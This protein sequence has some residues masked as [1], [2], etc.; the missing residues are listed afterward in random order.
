[1]QLLSLCVKTVY[2]WLM[3]SSMINDSEAS[4]NFLLGYI[5]VN[6]ALSSSEIVILFYSA[7]SCLEDHT[8]EPCLL[9]SEACLLNNGGRT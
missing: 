3:G 5:K 4:S 1:M 7:L 6:L 9:N 2:V 8:R